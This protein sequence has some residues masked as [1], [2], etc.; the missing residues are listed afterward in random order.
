MGNLVE[1][2]V[3]KLAG[4][5]EE[6]GL[7]DVHAARHGHRVEILELDLGHHVLVRLQRDLED[8]ALLR[9]HQKE[10]HRLGLVGGAAHKDHAALRIVEIVAPPGDRATDVRLIAEILV[11]DVVLG[12]DEHARGAVVAA[13][14]RGIRKLACSSSGSEYFLHKPNN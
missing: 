10:E 8:V 7:E 9:L 5:K 13:W 2:M 4:H 14:H 6:A 1:I 11:G 3:A 12:A